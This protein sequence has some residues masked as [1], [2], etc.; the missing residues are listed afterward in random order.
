MA[1]LTEMWLEQAT[2]DPS[3][4]SWAQG[5]PFRSRSSRSAL[6]LLSFAD[7]KVLHLRDVTIQYPE[8]VFQWRLPRLHTLYFSSVTVIAEN[9]SYLSSEPLLTPSTLPALTKLFYT[10]EQSETPPELELIGPQLT[11]LYLFR[12]PSPTSNRCDAIPPDLFAQLSALKHLFYDIRSISDISL[13]DTL[14]SPILSLQLFYSSRSSKRVEE[15][16]AHLL[17]PDGLLELE[18]LFLPPAHEDDIIV[19]SLQRLVLPQWRDAVEEWIAPAEVREVE[20]HMRARR[21]R[22]SMLG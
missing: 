1:F 22:R 10:W 16:L 4:L 17:L 12:T 18:M 6:T 5:K 14:A 7:L 9:R 13:L 19:N 2:F 3:V 20:L 8:E 21:T 11:H 15:N